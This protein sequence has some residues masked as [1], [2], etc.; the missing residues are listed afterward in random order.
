MVGLGAVPAAIQFGLLFLLPES[1]TSSP[2]LAPRFLLTH[3][4]ESHVL[5]IVARILLLRNNATQ[6]AQVLQKVYPYAT[7]EQVQLKVRVLQAAVRKSVQIKE[8]TTVW[9]RMYRVIRIPA[10]RRALSV[11]SLPP[12]FSPS[13][14][15][16]SCVSSNCLRPS[17]ISTTFRLQLAHVFLCHALR[18]GRVRQPYSRRTHR[19]RNELPFHTPRVE[20]YRSRRPT[21]HHAY[22]RAWYGYRPNGR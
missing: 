1:R 12:C 6:T 3:A 21:T 10:N 16:I 9:E 5:S 13:R 11:Y 7:T 4:C 17:S 18:L 2:L 15:N 20:I 22:Q 19:R 14:T 8:T